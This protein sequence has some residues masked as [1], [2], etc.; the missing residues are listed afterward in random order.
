MTHITDTTDE[1]TGRGHLLH[2]IALALL[3]ATLVGRVVLSEM[4]FRTSPL[5]GL[6]AGAD[7]E[8]ART[9]LLPNH[10][11]LASMTFGVVI[12]LAGVL[13]LVGEAMRRR[14]RV[15][16]GWLG[17]TIAI[18]AAWSLVSA[19]RAGDRRGALLFWTNQVT[20]M[21]AGWLAIQ[22]CTR[23]KHRSA[24]LAVLAALGVM[25]AIVGLRQCFVDAPERAADFKA[26]SAQILA[27]RGLAPDSPELIAFKERLFKAVP[28]GFFALANVFASVMIVLAA[29]AIGLVGD[30]W[31]KVLPDRKATAHLRKRGDIHLPTLAAA[32]ATIAPPLG[33]A[34]LVLALSRGATGA[35]AVA[36]VAAVVVLRFRRPLAAHWRRWVV[37]AVLLTGAGAA[38]VIAYGLKHDSLGART[39]TFRWYYWTAGVEIAADEPLWGVGP[40]GFGSAYE[41][42]R[43]PAGEESVKT[44]HNFVVH[45]AAQYGLVGGFCYVTV[46]AMVLWG[47]CRPVRHYPESIDPAQRSGLRPVAMII[48]IPLIVV[49]SQWLFGGARGEAGAV[50][51]AIEP[52][53]ILAVAL[54]M[55]LWWGPKLSPAAAEGARVTRVVLACG[56]VA[57]VAHNTVSFSLWMPG[58]A[59]AFWLAAGA[60]ISLRRLKVLDIS[61]LRWVAAGGAIASTIAVI[62][63]L[64]LPVAK[65]SWATEMAAGSL[66]ARDGR[67]TLAWARRAAECDTLDPIAAADAARLLQKT[68]RKAY[69]EEAYRWAIEAIRRDP[70]N[71]SN[72]R[73]AADILWAS[74]GNLTAAVG[75]MDDAVQRDPQSLS[76]RIEFAKKLVSEGLGKRALEQLRAAEEIHDALLPDSIFRLNADAMGKLQ[77]LKARAV[78]LAGQ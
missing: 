29:S 47:L 43:R 49:A 34:A 3:L 37:V 24:L 13:W 36:G 15:R 46:V 5:A 14:L 50:Y 6:D 65:R 72:H 26:R 33:A 53:V 45:A 73:L 30:R 20:L 51:N 16:A 62:A 42:H 78:E 21:L 2:G 41:A 57:F 68:G 27:A 69:L 39:M 32:V 61:P 71:S 75:H 31:W 63:V 40:G 55:M 56:L 60:V 8:G 25:L 48:W 58:A 52:A 19:L 59:I 17:I 76:M 18:F 66:I 23:P 77:A 10:I 70:R 35:A 12:S 28:L 1:T 4:P 38:A 22:L 7:A 67:A 64:W 44:P 54:A 11:D 9:I 74:P